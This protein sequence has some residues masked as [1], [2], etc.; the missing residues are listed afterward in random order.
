M[1]ISDIYLKNSLS[2]K[3]E[4]KKKLFFGSNFTPKVGNGVFQFCY[5]KGDGMERGNPKK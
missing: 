2:V 3:D 4:G 1:Y 5:K